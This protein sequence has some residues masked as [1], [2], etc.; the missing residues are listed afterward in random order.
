[1][2]FNALKEANITIPFPQRDLHILSKPAG[3]VPVG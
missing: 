1:V 3:E 2:I